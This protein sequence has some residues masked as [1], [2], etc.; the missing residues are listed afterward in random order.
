[1]KKVFYLFLINLLFTNILQADDK[2]GEITEKSG[3]VFY[4]EKKN[5]PYFDA[6]KGTELFNGNWIK[7]GPDGWVVLKL[8]DGSK[9]TLA[10]NK[11]IE[12]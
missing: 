6:K 4:R 12:I 7:T 1:M 5:I 3:K 8:A 2:I 10:N 11:E 9:L